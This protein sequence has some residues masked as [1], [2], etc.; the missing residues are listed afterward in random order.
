MI[1][2]GISNVVA[3]MMILILVI[4]LALPFLFYY[5]SMQTYR[6]E[7][8]AV[9]NNYQYLKNLQNK[10]VTSGHPAIYYN[11]TIVILQYTNGTFVPPSNLTI[12]NIL[13][14]NSQGIW[15]SI[16]LNYPIVVNTGQSINLPSYTNGRPIIIVTS[17]GNIFFLTPGSSIGPIGKAGKGGVEIIAQIANSSIV[18]GVSA[19]VTTNIYGQWK[20]FTTPVAFPNQSG[21]FQI[22][23][24]QY[25]Y[26][27]NSK[28]QIIT[29]VFRN[30]YVI[31]GAVLNSTTTQGIR[32]TLLGQ[33][34]VII[35]N[36]TPLLAYAYLK[37]QTNYLGNIS[38]SVN[39]K[40]Y[41]VN[42]GAQIQVPAGFVNFSV[43]TLQGNSSTPNII[44]HYS[45]SST[46]Y[47]SRNI[48]TYS[49]IIFLPPNSNQVITINYVNDY[50]YYNV[51]LVAYNN[52]YNN[53]LGI[54]NNL[55]SYGNSYWIIG[56]NYSFVPIGTFN[57]LI[58]YGV[59]N[60]TFKYLNGTTVTYNFP[61]LPSYIV[62]NQPMTIICY[63]GT[64][65]VW[66]KLY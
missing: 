24:P 64:Q 47:Q 17:L 41:N 53:P 13:Y 48:Y 9:V 33:P 3:L 40:V 62:I 37:I 39:G 38:I 10:Q 32:V 35:A 26:Y 36:Y 20:N 54:G 5:V 58:T 65:L 31:G 29:G 60:A 27:Q 2:K 14:L 49:G 46:Q 8:N 34:A 19:N 63:F 28:G 56:G 6:Q 4:A 42:N 50:N 11:G 30:W 61:N 15:V 23:A 57:G 21:T 52:I 59:V 22:K 43:L 51:T 25:V 66:V 12:V 7:S 55:Y 44:Y 1:V 18:L 45:Y 16:P